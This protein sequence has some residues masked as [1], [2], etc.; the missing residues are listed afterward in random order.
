MEI[1]PPE[2]RFFMNMK[3]LS[4]VIYDLVTEMKTKNHIE[5]DPSLISMA[6][7]ILF[8]QFN[9]RSMI[10]GFITNSHHY[11]CKHTTD[12]KERWCE[13]I[14]SYT[15]ESKT[16][17]EQHKVDKAVI[18]P[19]GSKDILG[20][21]PW[22]WSMIKSRNEEFMAENAF[23]I[24]TAVPEQNIAIFRDLFLRRDGEDKYIV[25]DVWRNQ[26]WK[27][28]DTLVKASIH[29]VHENRCPYTVVKDGKTE[30]HYRNANFY[31]HI[32]TLVLAKEW[33]LTLRW[34]LK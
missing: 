14:A 24:F 10:E 12:P 28:L 9:H 27:F 1:P 29:Y 13:H 5:L 34:N 33:G 25:S 17:C 21:Q 15:F 30:W 3:E 23:R 22:Q 31:R 8:E 7:V 18:L 19:K 4:G 2:D 26:I 20:K 6:S 32:D 16:Y 11:A